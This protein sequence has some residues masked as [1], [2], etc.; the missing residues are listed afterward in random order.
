[1]LD[2][3]KDIKNMIDKEEYKKASEYIEKVLKDNK[4]ASTYIEDLVNKLK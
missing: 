4:D 2:I 3:L 1:M